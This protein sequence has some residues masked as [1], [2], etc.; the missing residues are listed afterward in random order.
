MALNFKDLL[1]KVDSIECLSGP[2]QICPDVND[3]KQFSS[4]KAFQVR[5]LEHLCSTF[6]FAIA[7]YILM[8]F[9]CNP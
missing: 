3:C 6:Q 4:G 1:K 5:V 7:F 9:R 8:A 2:L